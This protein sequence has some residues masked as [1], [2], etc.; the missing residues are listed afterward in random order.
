MTIKH[1]RLACWIPKAAN[2]LRLFNTHCF[3]KAT[4]VTGTLLNVTLYVHYRS[5]F[6][7]SEFR[8]VTVFKCL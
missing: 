7:Y 3:P 2:T 5:C 4:M 1:M 6:S 8:W